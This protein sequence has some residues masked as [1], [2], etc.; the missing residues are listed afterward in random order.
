MWLYSILSDIIEAEI[1][2]SEGAQELWILV[3]QNNQ[4]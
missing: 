1:R 3:K 2:A 4:K